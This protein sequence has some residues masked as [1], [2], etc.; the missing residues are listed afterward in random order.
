MKNSDKRY[1]FGCGAILQSDDPSQSGYIPLKAL[2]DDKAVLCQRCFRIQN[3]RQEDNI[4]PISGDYWKILQKARRKRA[5]IV[6]VIDFFTYD[7]SFV[8]QVNAILKGLSILIVA[9]K[10]DI[11]PKSLNDHDLMTRTKKIAVNKGLK[12]VD[13]LLTSA[14]KNYHIDELLC[15]INLYRK[16]H[17][18]Y[19]VG[20]V[21]AGKSSLINALL[22]NYINLTSH[23]ITT[24]PFP[25]TTLDVIEV[26]LDER[27]YIY[28]TPGLPIKGSL[29]DIVDRRLINDIIPQKEMKARIYQITS[30]QS[31]L[32]GGLARFDYLEG[33]KSNF[34]VYASE[35]ILIQRSK[36]EKAS[37]SFFSL[38]N[39]GQIKPT[40]THFQNPE[41]FMTNE[42]SLEEGEYEICIIGYCWIIVKAQ[43]MKIAI[44]IPKNVEI[45]IRRIDQNME[46][47]C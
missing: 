10:R 42:Y 27:S 9:N 40:D 1:C 24:S 4:L 38:I 14:E 18:V 39:S 35:R 16:G 30:K 29:L 37:K 7:F 46:E 33:P 2:H 8:D 5:L 32:I 34:V 3:Y 44:T 36:L 21:S 20:S 23:L 45:N 26:P 47:L 22:K 43:F 6:Y 31:L 11:L 13:I 28:D 19:V 15:K 41:D 12:I 25:G 17:D